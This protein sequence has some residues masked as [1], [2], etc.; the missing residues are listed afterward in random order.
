[1]IDKHSQTWG[2]VEAHAKEQIDRALKALETTR[3]DIAE[4]EYQ[5]G[6]IKAYRAI[7]ALADPR[8]KI[9]G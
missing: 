3:T 8:P 4:T 2:A 9:P 7:L 5:R 6:K 1:M